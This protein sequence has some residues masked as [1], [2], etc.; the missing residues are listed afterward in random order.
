MATHKYT[1]PGT[2]LDPHPTRYR[3]Q[4]VVTFSE[5]GITIHEAPFLK[6]AVNGQALQIVDSRRLLSTV[7]GAYFLWRD[8]F[9]TLVRTGT[10]VV[11]VKPLTETV[12]V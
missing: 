6:D 3:H 9:D 4:Q 1:S 7:H 5:K 2:M 11:L 8:C 10:S 12:L